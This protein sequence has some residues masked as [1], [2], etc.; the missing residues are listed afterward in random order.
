MLVA[1][2]A[3]AVISMVHGYFDRKSAS[4]LIQQ[5]KPRIFDGSLLSAVGVDRYVAARIHLA[6]NHSCNAG[7]LVDGDRNVFIVD[8][9]ASTTVVR[10]VLWQRG[11]HKMES[12]SALQRWHCDNFPQRFI[13]GESIR[14]HN[15][16][17]LWHA[18]LEED[19]L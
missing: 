12:F 6:S 16:R 18:S 1:L 11:V 14:N 10:I 5:W 15:D 4:S 7:A 19:D 9:N 3:V 17:M 13:T 8:T 2:A